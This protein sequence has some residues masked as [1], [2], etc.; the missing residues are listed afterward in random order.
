V[1]G[2]KPWEKWYPQRWL[3]ETRLR[4]CSREA[5]S[6]W[7]DCLCLMMQENSYRLEVEGRPATV[8]DLSRILGDDP[9]TV[10]RLLKELRERGVYDVDGGGFIFSLLNLTESGDGH[11]SL[12]I[13]LREEIL[14]RDGKKCSYCGQVDGPMEIDHILPVSRGG[15]DHPRNLTVACRPCNRSKGAKT[16]GEWLG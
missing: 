1:S 10:R 7:L 4:L 12:P 11:R 6:F 9:R 3:S 8:D 2:R 15:R 5:R 16:P 14:Q 13:A